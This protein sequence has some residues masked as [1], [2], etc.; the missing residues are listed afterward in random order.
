M[1]T[2]NIIAI[3]VA[4]YKRPSLLK[5]C[6]SAIQ[7]LNLPDN[8]KIIIIVVDNDINETARCIVEDTSKN[9]IIPVTYYVESER[10]I[11][12]ARNRLLQ[13]ALKHG[14]E[15]IGFIDDDEFPHANWLKSHLTAIH[16]YDVDIVAGPVIPT[17][18]TTPTNNIK[19]EIKYPTGYIPRNIA[20]GNV[21]FKNALV[22]KDKLYFNTYYNFIGGEDF[23]FFYRAT[24]K[25][26]SKVWN[27]EAIIYETLPKERRTKKYLFFRHFTG[28]IN[29]VVYYKSK[30]ST[31][32]AWSHFLIKA[33]GKLVG[34]F[35][36]LMLFIFTLNQK[37]L[38]KSI[39][40]L[41][42]TVGYVSG[43]LNII[44]ERYR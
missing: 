36:D 40:K 7:L 10:G 4:T 38:E 30:K 34:A 11:A 6:L 19:I 20:A 26:F 21:M 31:L 1:V 3:C 22:V 9:S 28:A 44:V 16:K 17:H 39:V 42:S 33:I 13:E 27:A 18:E 23:D 15:L 12:T 37:K 41:A 25:G 24:K 14:A 35:I 43:L 32:S 29:N 2:N 8:Y 5:N